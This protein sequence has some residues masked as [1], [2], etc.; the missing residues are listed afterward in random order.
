MEPSFDD[1]TF[2]R[3]NRQSVVVSAFTVYRVAVVRV[4]LRWVSIY[5]SGV[6][7]PAK[8]G[9][10]WNFMF[11]YSKSSNITHEHAEEERKGKR[12]IASTCF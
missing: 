4:A 10:R 6:E 7:V 5:A 2:V 3:G 1:D 12:H 11:V 8:I 9:M